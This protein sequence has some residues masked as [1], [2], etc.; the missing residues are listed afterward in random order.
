MEPLVVDWSAT[1]AKWKGAVGSFRLNIS[2]ISRESGVTRQHVTS[3]LAG[4]SVPSMVV[5]ER[6]DRAI[7]AAVERRK[8]IAR[9][10]AAGLKVLI[11][12]GDIG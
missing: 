2:D 6:I 10:A 4:L 8:V 3:I 1:L 11:E 7:D 5:A 9:E 12:R